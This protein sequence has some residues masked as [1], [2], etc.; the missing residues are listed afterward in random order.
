MRTKYRERYSRHVGLQSASPGRRL[1]T[2]LFRRPEAH[3]A[4]IR[5]VWPLAVGE[6][7]ALRSEVVALEGR[8]ARIRVADAGWR[9]A[10]HSSQRT[11][12]GRLKGL[13]GELAPNR[14]GIMEGPVETAPARSAPKTAGKTEP[15]A[16]LV[17]AAQ[18]IPDDS[19]RREFLET[20]ARYQSRFGS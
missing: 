6:G 1:A 11:I 2:E 16:D 17:A 18:E 8:T 5:A 12:L 14:L 20:A 15:S 13:A 10:I 3:L 9:R 4:L 7:L 19:L